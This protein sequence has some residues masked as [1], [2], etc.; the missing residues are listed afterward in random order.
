MAAVGVPL[1]TLMFVFGWLISSLT[2]LVWFSSFYI[3][4][5]GQSRSK[6]LD[7]ASM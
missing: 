7:G 6:I 4:L 3:G 5:L 1:M 2:T